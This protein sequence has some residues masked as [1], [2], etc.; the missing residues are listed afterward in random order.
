MKYVLAILFG[1][2]FLALGLILNT[3]VGGA[4]GWVIGTAF[5]F[6]PETLGTALGSTLTGFEAGA[7]LG[8]V[9]GFFRFMLSEAKV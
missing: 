6:I 2:V 1:F 7:V 9:S 4:V 3:F 8:F 5:P